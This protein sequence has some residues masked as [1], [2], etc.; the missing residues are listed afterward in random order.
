[1]GEKTG[2]SEFKGSLL[3]RIR[4]SLKGG[5]NPREENSRMSRKTGN[6]KMITEVPT[7]PKKSD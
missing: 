2:S 1:L 5:R 7:L 3:L 6:G 4:K